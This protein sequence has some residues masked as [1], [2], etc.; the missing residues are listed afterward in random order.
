MLEASP[1][2][3]V[4]NIG[5]LSKD[6]SP[7]PSGN[8]IT[9]LNTIPNGAFAP[10]VEGPSGF[11][12]DLPTR[13]ITAGRFSAVDFVGGH[14]TGDGKFFSGGTPENFVTDDDIRTRVF[15][16]WPAVVSVLAK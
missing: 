15:S 12:P 10:I 6:Q 11:M 9:A 8:L 3:C 7:C 14:C 16:R 1:C 4:K 5:F 2:Q 13:L